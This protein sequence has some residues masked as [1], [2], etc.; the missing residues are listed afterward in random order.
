MPLIQINIPPTMSASRNPIG[1]KFAATGNWRTD[2]AYKVTCKI[3]EETYHHSNVYTHFLTLE[4]RP[5]DDNIISFDI[6]D[7]LATL[8][9][10]TEKPSTTTA[11]TVTDINKRYSIS[12]QESG[13]NIYQL[14]T[15][16]S[17]YHVIKAGMSE[18][19]GQSIEDQINS[20]LFLTNQPRI[21]QTTAHAPEYLTLGI[22]TTATAATAQMKAVVIYTDDTESSVFSGPQIAYQPGD[23]IQFHAG[24]NMLGLQNITPPTDESVVGYKIWI[25]ETT[26]NTDISDLMEYRFDDCECT[27][28]TRYF[29]FENTYGGIDTIITSGKSETKM[30]ITGQQAQRISDPF[31]IS[32]ERTIMD[33]SIRH[34]EQVT[35]PIGHQSEESQLW[36]RE[37][38]RTTVAWR[39]GNSPTPNIEAEGEWVPISIK[40]GESLI[41]KDNEFLNSLSFSYKEAYYQHGT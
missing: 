40:K 35:Q 27:P 14:A 19:K 30:M 2:S 21:K 13:N 18:Q 12:F 36:L 16:Y 6:S 29:C 10:K 1:W 25:E 17:A 5:D 22:P 8:V 38:L 11:R 23:M 4:K 31:R 26:G 32:P 9:P 7:I 41:L 39:V 3:F 28:L 20:Q 37:L 34:Q 24:Y 15:T 33:Y